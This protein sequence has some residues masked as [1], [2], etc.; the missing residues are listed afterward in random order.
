MFRSGTLGL[1][2][3]LGR[4]RE[5]KVECIVFVGQN[6]K[7]WSICCGSVQHIAHACREGFRAKFKELIGDSFEQLS[8]IDRTACV[9]SSE[10]NFED[11]LRLMR[12][13]H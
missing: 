7:V 2:E 4:H 11:T 12:V 10:L 3:E 8:D 6:V 13:Y 5:G 9:L 1:N